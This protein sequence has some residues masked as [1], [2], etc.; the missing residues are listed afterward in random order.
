MPQIIFIVIISIVAFE[1]VLERYLSF[2]NTRRMSDPIPDILKGIYD[3]Q[4]YQKQ[5]LYKRT[6]DRF[7]NLTSTFSFL[8]VMSMLLFS[9]FAWLH[10]WISS[11]IFHPIAIT[12]IFFGVIM[13][14]S[15][16]LGIPFEWYATFVIEEKFGFNKT[17][18]K[19]FVLDKLKSWLLTIIIGG[20]LLTLFVWFYQ[21][22]GQNFWIYVWMVFTAFTIFMVMFYSNLIV[23]LFNKQTPLETGPLREAI[24]SFSNKAGFKLKNIFVIDGS[25]RST[26]ANAYFTGLGAK[27][28]IV[29]YDNLIKQ[30]EINEIVAVLAHEIGHYKK[31]HTVH[32][33]LISILSTGFTL[34]LLSLFI[35]NPIFT[36]ALGVKAPALHIALVSFGVLYSP[37]SMIT[38][39]FGNLISRKNEYQADEFASSFGLANELI[40][41]LKKLSVNNLSNLT[42]HPLYVFFNYSHPTLYQRIMKLNKN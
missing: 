26:K 36:E 7:S 14:V 16:F 40:S 6:N 15:D 34:F 13:L 23:P 32:G 37:I 24:E 25:K 31:K 3:D 38:G 18:P 8:L 10:N 17:T 28:R 39:I 4:T 5:Q 22:V 19:I 42:P 9:G 27:K 21:T 12:L 1:F 41:A 30:M 33:L 35:S 2:I 20:T 11:W 29:L